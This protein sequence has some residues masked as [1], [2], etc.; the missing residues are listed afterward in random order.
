MLIVADRVPLD[1]ILFVY[2]TTGFQTAFGSL[3]LGGESVTSAHPLH[4][5]LETCMSLLLISKPKY[6]VIS[7][8]IRF[9]VD[10]CVASGHNHNPRPQRRYWLLRRGAASNAGF[11]RSSRTG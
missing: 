6:V 5:T 11:N 3:V 8:V 4:T 10:G 2:L 9:E 1:K 7:V